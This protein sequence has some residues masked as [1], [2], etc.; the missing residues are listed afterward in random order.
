MT[1]KEIKGNL[2]RL[3]ATENLVVEH[4]QTPT[5]YFNVDTRVLVLPKWDKASDVVYDMLV[6]HEVGH[7]L[8][9]PNVDFTEQVSCPRDYVNVIEDARIEKL[10]KRKYPGLKKSFVG[11]YTELNDKDFFQ[12]F[13]KDLTEL[14]LI[15]RIN[16]HFKLGAHAMMPFEGAEYVFVARADLAET[17]DEVCKIAQDVY[18][19]AK[20]QE[21]EQEKTE[22]PVSQTPSSTGGDTESDDEDGFGKLQVDIKGDRSG[23]SSTGAD[24][25]DVKDDWYDEDGNMTEPDDGESLDDLLDGEGD[26]NEGGI[27]SSATQQAFN[28]AQ[29][30][31]SS[32][33][34]GQPT[35]YVEI[36]ENVDTSKHVVDWKTI[37]TW[38]D[39]QRDVRDDFTDVD[40]DYRKF[41]KQSQKEVNYMVKEFECRKSADAYARASTAKTGVLNTGMLHTYKYNEDLFKRVTVI[42]DGKNHGMIFVLDWSGSMCY[43]LLATVKQLI[44]L[45]SFCKKVQIPFEV[46]AFTNEW[47]AAQRAI[48]NDATI[49]QDTPYYRSYYDVDENDLEKNKVYIDKWFYLMNFVSSRSNGKDYER[50]CLNLFREASKHRRYGSYSSTI[51]LG[52]SGTPLNESIVM[53]NHILP[54]FK[55][56]NS[57]QKV[58]VCILT[59]GEACT[60]SYGAEYDRGEGEVVIRARRLDLGVALRDR[61]TGRTYEQFT[62]STTTNI[63]L[64]QLRDR[65]PDVNVLG[66]RILSGSA[67]MSFVSNYGSPDCNYAEIQKQWK[68]EKSAVITSPAGFTELYAINNKALD[69]DTEFVVKDNAKKGDITRAFKKMLA[70]K[71]VN[72][73]LLNA[74]VSKV[75]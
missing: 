72:K 68:K 10:M 74:F 69:N 21:D 46:Y 49:E 17:F 58:N 59:D 30:N 25:E 56:D 70:N 8:F 24:L 5:A 63:F 75:S 43:E 54:K 33:D 22:V 11:G 4:K 71:S 16:L 32:I 57:L 18:N 50:M 37:H 3:L 15:D 27:D 53:L 13:D 45:T 34:H 29:E 14:S 28:E 31:L 39:S 47:G 35:T 6:G 42:P 60:S 7:A 1:N 73:K 61:T 20:T 23:G 19:Y 9:T 2:A 66:F 62:Y 48:D 12:I 65:N 40:D 67:L 52:L 55:K 26:D 44:N 41:R 51:G 64:K 36:P 38:I